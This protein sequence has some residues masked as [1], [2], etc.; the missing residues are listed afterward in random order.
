MSSMAE[1]AFRRDGV[2]ASASETGDEPR[3]SAHSYV[4]TEH[5]DP[6]P[7]LPRMTPWAPT[8]IATTRCAE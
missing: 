1:V 4:I 6:C 5:C 8:E 7:L 2:V 3:S